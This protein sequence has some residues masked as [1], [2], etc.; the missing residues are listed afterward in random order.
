VAQWVTKPKEWSRVKIMKTRVKQLTHPNVHALREMGLCT[1]LGTTVADFDGSPIA[2]CKALE[3]AVLELPAG[4]TRRS[5]QA[6][7]RKLRDADR[8]YRAADWTG[9]GTFAV[10]RYVTVTGE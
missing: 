6:V 3:A 5:V 2:A 7:R 8:A 10:T 9:A 4:Y 1:E